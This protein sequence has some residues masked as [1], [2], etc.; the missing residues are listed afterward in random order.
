M[1]DLVQP[2]ERLGEISAVAAT[3]TGIPRG[4]PLVAAAADKACE[5]MGAGCLSPSQA[6]ISYGTA[7]AINVVSPRYIEP[8]PLFPAYPSAWPGRYNLEVQIFSGFWLVSWFIREFGLQEII[9]AAEKQVAP[10]EIL[11][12]LIEAIPPGAQ[13]LLVQPYW[14]P[15]LGR[16][17]LEARGTAMG[18]RHNHTRAHLYLALLEGLAL[19]LREGKERLE[20]R[21]GQKVT[22]LCISGGG[23]RS[24]RMTEITADVFNLPVVRAHT[25]ETA[26]LGAAVVAAVGSKFFPDFPTA[27]AAMVRYQEA[28]PPDAAR[29]AIYEDIYGR[30]Y[31]PLYRRL[32]PLYQE[33]ERREGLF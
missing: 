17:G 5:A 16:P 7:A 27:V 19:A 20:R 14:V 31:Q 18:F 21:T 1:C 4:T 28:V 10:E 12:A 29:A 11:D 8:L 25:W 26:A 22:H 23:A 3:A 32:K 33:I 2:G 6:N 24:T 15:G 30:V 9:A 13:G